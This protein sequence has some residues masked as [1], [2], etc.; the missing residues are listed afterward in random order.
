M[1]HIL[2]MAHTIDTLGKKMEKTMGNDISIIYYIYTFYY[3][4]YMYYIFD[5][6]YIINTHI[7]IYIYI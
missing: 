3:I 7:H 1:F 4:H 6:V 5:I 2:T